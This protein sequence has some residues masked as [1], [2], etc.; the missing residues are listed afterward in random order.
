MKLRTILILSNLLSIS[1]IIGFLIISYV[2][3]FLSTDVIILLSSITVGAGLLSVL[4]HLAVTHPLLKGVRQ[5][6]ETSKVVAEGQFDVKVEE[7]G[8]KEFKELAQHFNHMSTNLDDLFHK[9]KASEKFKRDLIANMS[10][11]LKTPVASIKSYVEAMQDDIIT[12]EETKKAYLHTIHTET[13]RLSALIQELLDLSRLEQ[14]QSKG[15]YEL[16][17]I[18]Q[19]LL[20][21]LQQFELL[22]REKELDAQVEL[23]NVLEPIE[24][25]PN[26]MK[27]VLSN[28]LDNA[29]RYTSQ[30]GEITISVQQDDATT[31]F[32]VLDD[33]PG[34]RE[35][36]QEAIFE[37]F[38][39]VEPS[40]NKSYGGSGLGLA[41]CKEIVEQHGGT[42][43]VESEAGAG[44]RFTFTLH[45]QQRGEGS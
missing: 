43:N 28:L 39:R 5:L 31:T 9:V 8:P 13:D 27:R 29:V 11:D 41:I 1:I 16:V 21:T 6:S 20:E 19:L 10:H 42:L 35:E 18:D 3:M 36:H 25:M 34:I 14:E 38:Y 33:G 15:E 37:R 26:Q 30:Q 23:P 24:V 4:L 44:S 32:T 40:R 22:L 45:N 12:D 2:R 7:T 17:H